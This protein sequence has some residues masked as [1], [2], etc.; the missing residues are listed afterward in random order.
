M[1]AAQRIGIQRRGT[2]LHRAGRSLVLRNST[3]IDIG[4]ALPRP[5]QRL[6]GGLGPVYD[7]S[8][9]TCSTKHR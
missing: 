9:T 3:T 4:T 1:L 2:T 8:A 6:V 5:L 7:G